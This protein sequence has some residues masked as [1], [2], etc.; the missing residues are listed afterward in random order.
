MSGNEIVLKEKRK[1]NL[2]SIA[3]YICIVALVIVFTV[4]CSIKGIN[5]LSWKNITNIFVQS[6]V[7]GIMA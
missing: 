5:Y 4:L 6:S 7:I 2:T 1:V 3:L